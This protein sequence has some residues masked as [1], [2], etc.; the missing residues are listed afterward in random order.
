M[1][2]LSLSK[3]YTL[4]A[5]RTI[6]LATLLLSL[7]LLLVTVLNLGDGGAGVTAAGEDS[8]LSEFCFY[9]YDDD[10][11]DDECNILTEAVSVELR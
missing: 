6:S 2:S 5:F 8:R 10:F 4:V 1:L 7:V 3:S 9:G 11:C